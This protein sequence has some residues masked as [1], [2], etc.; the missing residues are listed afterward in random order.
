MSERLEPGDAEAPDPLDA[1][2]AAWLVRLEGGPLDRDE[3]RA[4]EAWLDAGPGRLARLAEARA[5]W[6]ELDYLAA[7]VR[8]REARGRVGARYGS[9]LATGRSARRRGPGRGARSRVAAA[10]A[11]SLLLAAT[12]GAFLLDDPLVALTADHRAAPGEILRV[13]L[14]DGSRAELDSGAA[15]AV[16][17]DGRHR[18]VELLAGRAAF[19]ALP[20]SGANG[21]PFVVIAAGGQA[22]ALGTE[23][24]VEREPDGAAV[25]VIRHHVAVT[26][27]EG[28]DR[29]VL[30]P[31]QRVVFSR[32]AGIGPPR[33]A[34]A[35]AL[36]P[37][38]EGRLVFE[39]VPLAAAVETLNRYRRGRILL[40]D[41]ALAG[42]RV[43]GV[44]NLDRI[45][46]ALELIASELELRH[47]SLPPF[48]T[49][50]Y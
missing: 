22:E 42:R 19:T 21:R 3:Q 41:E 18:A 23:F 24:L 25:T 48:V 20:A 16:R 27:P 14:P 47:A 38:R 36:A 11:A 33:E 17:Y 12:L 5:A 10:L 32:D 2:A 9:L 44:F 43:S 26:P 6:G 46:G 31:G 40:L 8:T 49:V 28:E 29:L 1:E 35:G 45:D 13:V 30:G 4:F 7:A 34:A 15:L 37:W 50:L 39:Q